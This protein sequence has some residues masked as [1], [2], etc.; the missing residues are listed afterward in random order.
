MVIVGGTFEVEPSQ[1]ES[2][3]AGRMDVMRA[4]R[5][6]PGCLEYTF[7]ADPLDASHVVLFER[8]AS[9]EDLD[10]HLA[11]MRGA[12]RKP[13]PDVVPISSVITIYDVSGERRL[14]G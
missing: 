13:E 6:E 1:R 4:S 11:A 14:G 2:F 12:P 5:A 7:A 8:W 10:A 3:L 9:Q